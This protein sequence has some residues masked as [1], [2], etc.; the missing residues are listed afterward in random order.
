M[1]YVSRDEIERL[2]DECRSMVMKRASLSAGAAVVPVPALDVGTD[3][4]LLLQMLP[5]ITRKFRLSEDDL[6]GDPK[7][8]QFVLV[9]ALSVGSEMIGRVVTKQIV[10][11]LLKRVGIRVASKSVAKYVP[12]LGSVVSAGLSF[13]VMRYVGN[14]H[15]EDC[16]KVALKVLE[17]QASALNDDTTD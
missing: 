9:A 3:V 12:L 5:A 7:L 6:E 8:R 15:V 16:Y 14:D 17:R 2:R 11:Q 1:T 4:A 10:M 13:G